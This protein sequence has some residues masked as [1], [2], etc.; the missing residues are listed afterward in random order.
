LA[1]FHQVVDVV[2]T[3]FG[4]FRQFSAKK[5]AFVSKSNI[6]FFGENIFKIVT[7]I[8]GPFFAGELRRHAG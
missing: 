4:D 3:I 7:S 5:L 8:P 2:I 6:T 1:R